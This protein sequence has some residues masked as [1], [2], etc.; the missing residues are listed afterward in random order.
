VT[1]SRGSAARSAAIAEPTMPPPSTSAFM[2]GQV[3]GFR[4]RRDVRR[5]EAGRY[6]P[7]PVVRLEERA[8]HSRRSAPSPTSP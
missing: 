7:R 1:D 2:G 6:N 4:A 5:A 8:C 3:S